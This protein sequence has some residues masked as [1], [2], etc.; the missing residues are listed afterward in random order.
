MPEYNLCSNTI[1]D[2]RKLLGVRHGS[3]ESK[4]PTNCR[5]LFAIERLLAYAPMDYSRLPQ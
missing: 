4:S 3:I 2:A 5:F 1:R